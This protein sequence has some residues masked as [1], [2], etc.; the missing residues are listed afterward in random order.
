MVGPSSVELAECSVVVKVVAIRM[1][2][3]VAIF[4]VVILECCFMCAYCP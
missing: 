1:C 4:I 3:V 2:N